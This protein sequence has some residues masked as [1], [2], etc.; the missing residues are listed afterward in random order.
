[1]TGKRACISFQILGSNGTAFQEH[2]I[3]HIVNDFNV[4]HDLKMSFCDEEGQDY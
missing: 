4:C 2:E 1:M 3:S